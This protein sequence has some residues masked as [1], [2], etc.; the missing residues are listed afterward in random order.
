MRVHANL[1]KSQ[2]SLN[3][4]TSIMLYLNRSPK[5]ARVIWMLN[6]KN[7]PGVLWQNR[8]LATTHLIKLWLV[9]PGLL[10]D[11]THVYTVSALELL[12]LSIQ[13]HFLLTS[14]YL[15][16]IVKSTVFWVVILCNVVETYRRFR[17][18]NCL[19]FQSQNE[20]QASSKHTLQCESVCSSKAVV[21][22]CQITWHHT[23]EEHKCHI[24]K[25]VISL[26]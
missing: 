25:S 17:G 21:H 22:V 3:L 20:S 18:T 5:C 7:F 14:F 8:T 11:H 19:H 10:L 16:N 4:E 12:F 9:P 26:Q 1:W 24:L 6:V 23:P 13:L 2:D 15:K